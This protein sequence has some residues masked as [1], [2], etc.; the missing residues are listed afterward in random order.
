MASK[1]KFRRYYPPSVPFGYVIEHS[2][3]QIQFYCL[4]VS[5]QQFKLSYLLQFNNIVLE[6]LSTITCSVHTKAETESK[7]LQ[8]HPW[9]QPHNLINRPLAQLEGQNPTPP[10]LSDYALMW[11]KLRTRKIRKFMYI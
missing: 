10:H 9:L 5:V 2:A 6:Q 3:M 8:F 1:I 11:H 4:N 7:Y